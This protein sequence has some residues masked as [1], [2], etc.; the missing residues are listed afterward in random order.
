MT[1]TDRFE[2]HLPVL[3]TELA[4]P[5][6][7]DYLDDLLRLTAGTSQRPAWT[8]LERW[9]PMVDIAR[10]PVI[11]PPLPWRPIG[12]L[13]LLALALAAGA[14]LVIGSLPR[15]PQPFG[16]A[17]NG[18]VAYARDGD[19]FTF[20]PITQDAR[21]IIGSPDRDVGPVF[22]LDGTQLAFLRDGPGPGQSLMVADADGSNVT[23]VAGPFVAMANIA[24]SPDG[25]TIAFES[26]VRGIP[27]IT[28]AAADGSGARALDVGMPAQAPA[29][30][31]PDGDQLLF[32]GGSSSPGL[33]IVDAGGANPRQLALADD[34][35]LWDLF[36]AA[37]SPD[38]TQLA[39]HNTD[40]LPS[41]TVQPYGG[42]LHLATISDNGM[43]IADRR[44]EFDTD[45]RCECW[46]R[47]SPDGRQ[48]LFRHSYSTLAGR[49]V[50]EPMV[51]ASDGRGGARAIG[52][53]S[54][55]E[56]ALG[57]RRWATGF[58]GLPDS[59]TGIGFEWAP[60]GTS[61]LTINFR[62]DS[63][64][65]LDPAGG[66]ETR[67]NLGSDKTPTWQRLAP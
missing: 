63:T 7:P 14:M 28:L 30:R 21:R 44:L 37:W 61:V 12:I 40:T 10:Q 23:F 31:P 15:L 49:S 9:L 66:A 6:T 36:G 65:V 24:W 55:N 58:D 4:E 59:P 18:Q 5:R 54:S 64:W 32:R 11:A 41:S 22:S 25:A 38:G 26:S 19:V 33:F 2:R 53:T 20:D 17:R 56:R 60:D 34:A 46:A 39:Y 47:W 29:W 13:L 52:I 51:T 3:L 42:R 67:V 8:F 50:I 48:L 45:A 1:P 62:D 57:D 43:V 27:T 16:L 35:N